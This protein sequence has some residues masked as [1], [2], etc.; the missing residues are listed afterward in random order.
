MKRT[1]VGCPFFVSDMLFDLDQQ[2]VLQEHTCTACTTA[3]AFQKAFIS[4]ESHDE[5]KRPYD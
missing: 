1:A 2:S 5:G 3:K 4:R